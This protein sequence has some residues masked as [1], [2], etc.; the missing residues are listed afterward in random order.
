M[1]EETGTPREGRNEVFAASQ[2]QTAQ[3]VAGGHQTS[4]VMRD[5]FGYDVP[6]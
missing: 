2:A 1:S 3:Q 4:N 6:V 5:D